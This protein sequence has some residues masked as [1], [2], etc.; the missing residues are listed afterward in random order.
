MADR[1]VD[2]KPN[3]FQAVVK[4]LADEYGGDSAAMI[5]DL[6]KGQRSTKAQ[7]VQPRTASELVALKE[8]GIL[9][10]TEARKFLGLRPSARAKAAPSRRGNNP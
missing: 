4:I 1:V 10:Q 8:A 2:L 6:R 5:A 9:N 3:D 7:A